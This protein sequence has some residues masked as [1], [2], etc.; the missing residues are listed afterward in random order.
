[1]DDEDGLDSMSE[2]GGEGERG[3]AW[4]GVAVEALLTSSENSGLNS[5]GRDILDVVEIQFR[6][7]KIESLIL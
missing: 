1:V 7:S 6:F 2:G 4:R 3:G 5:R